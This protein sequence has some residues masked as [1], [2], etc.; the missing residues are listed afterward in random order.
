MKKAKE[1]YLSPMQ[2]KVRKGAK[3][4]ARCFLTVAGGKREI[5]LGVWG[6]PES[7]AKYRQIAAEYYSSG[8]VRDNINPEMATLSYLYQQF[9]IDADKRVLDPRQ[10]FDARELK[11]YEIVIRN[12]IDIYQDLLLKD[13]NATAYRTI[14]DHLVSIAPN[15]IKVGK[16]LRKGVWSANYVNKLMTYFRLIVRWGIGHDLI[17]PDVLN[18]FSCVEPLVSNL[19]V[20]APRTAIDDDIVRKTL[21]YMSPTVRDMVIIQRTHGLRPSAVCGLKIGDIDTKG[22][23]W[24]VTKED[25]TTYKTRVPLIIKFGPEDQ[26]ILKPRIAGR[27]KEEYVFTPQIARMERRPNECLKRNVRNQKKWSKLSDEEIAKTYHSDYYTVEKYSQAIRRAIRSARNAGIDVPDWCAYQL[28]HT[29]VTMVAY[30][31]GRDKAML[32]AGHQSLSMTDHYAHEASMVKEDLAKDI[33]PYWAP[34]GTIENVKS[35][36]DKKE[37]PKD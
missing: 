24:T 32:L 29:A 25:K 13:L 6:S 37:P 8:D 5:Y 1:F 14:R 34:C 31:Y 7:E 28:R 12:T 27:K 17:S 22:E 23:I 16:K 15:V 21:P 35:V 2:R 18:K 10:K 9:L 20:K 30:Q 4:T 19:K 11:H 3:D 33:V 36:A 26:R